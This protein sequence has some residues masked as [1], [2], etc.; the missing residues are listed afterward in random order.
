MKTAL[1]DSEAKDEMRSG[2]VLDEAAFKNLWAGA[3]QDAEA[4]LKSEDAAS[5]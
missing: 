2:P 5:A 4:A 1:A 3:P